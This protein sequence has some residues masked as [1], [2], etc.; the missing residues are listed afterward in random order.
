MTDNTVRETIAKNLLF[1][2][3]QHKMTQ[4]ELA[5]QLGVRN[6]AISNWETGVNSIDIDTLVKACEIFG[7]TINDMYEAQSDHTVTSS[8]MEHIK[9]YRTLDEYGKKN[10]DNIL[11]NEYNRC[12]KAA[13]GIIK[14]E[15][16]HPLPS[17]GLRA[18]HN[19]HADDP[20]ELEKI[21]QDLEWL[22][23]Q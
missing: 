16:S 21:K 9:K 5:L 7:T 15:D 11:D 18:A 4:K 13:A 3:K 10:V 1:Y 19:D 12:N 14:F 22:S 20:D 2:R 8:E 6:S 23:K 17:P